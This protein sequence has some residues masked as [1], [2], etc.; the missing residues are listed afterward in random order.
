VIA[1]GSNNTRYGD[2][3]DALRLLVREHIVTSA[4]SARP[5]DVYIAAVTSGKGGVG[6]TSI[7][8]NL[9]LLMARGGRSVR[10]VDADF[11]LANADVLLGVRPEYAMDDV[12]SGRVDARDAWTCVEP[13]LKLLS[14]GSGL[15]ELANLSGPAGAEL[16]RTILGSVDEGDTII[17]D[18]APGISESVVSL[19]ALA[20]EVLVVT[21]PEPTSLADSYAA[22]KV[23]TSHSPEARITLVANACDGPCQASAVASSL[24]AICRKFLGRGVQDHEF[25]PFDPAVGRAV[26]SRQP[27]AGRVGRSAIE[28]WLRKIAIKIEERSR[29]ARHFELGV[30]S[31]SSGSRAEGDFS[32][33]LRSGRNDGVAHRGPNDGAA[34]SGRNDG[35]AHSGRNDGVAHRGPNDGVAHRGRN[36]GAGAR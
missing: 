3:A 6:K 26:R 2:Q 17:I 10:L 15:E 34:H 19:L 31:H 29:T 16:L 4:V 32:T 27:V 11:G 1:T 25:L 28:P 33:P 9:A 14:C 36:D 18:T 24:E 22:I 30:R 35:A 12:M 5:S 7:A 20:D 13:G 8:V 23:L 21:T